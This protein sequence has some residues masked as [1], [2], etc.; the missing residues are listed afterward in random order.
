M[1]TEIDP[2]IQHPHSTPSPREKQ[3][4]KKK[5]RL[6]PTV[7][8]YTCCLPI[9]KDRYVVICPIERPLVPRL[10]CPRAVIVL[11]GDLV[12]P[13]HVREAVHGEDVRFVHAVVV[14]GSQAYDGRFGGLEVDEEIAG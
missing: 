1:T 3:K 5:K 6:G 8:V 9:P 10:R 2:Y 12:V 14:D 11:V 7:R 4:K 13:L